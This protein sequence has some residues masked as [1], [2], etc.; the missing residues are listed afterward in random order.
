MAD[1][2]RLAEALALLAEAAAAAVAPE[3]PLLVSTARAQRQVVVSIAPPYDADGPA[4]SSLDHDVVL[5]LRLLSRRRAARSSG[6]RTAC[7]IRA[8]LSACR[9]HEC[10]TPRA[11]TFTPAF[12]A[13]VV[14]CIRRPHSYPEARRDDPHS[15]HP[16]APRLETA[17]PW[18]TSAAGGCDA[19]ECT[20]LVDRMHALSHADWLALAFEELARA[21][22]LGDRLA[23]AAASLEPIVAAQKFALDVWCVRDAVETAL[24]QARDTATDGREHRAAL[25]AARGAAERAA[26]ACLMRPWLA[27][28]SYG[29]LVAPFAEG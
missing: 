16:I 10:F 24:A 18:G 13:F 21:A 8:R 7:G 20:A 6:G 22:A 26:L 5:A 12:T 11:R 19:A 23:A 4:R 17:V 1:R 25:A 29:L 2:V 9:F 3:R 15:A 14:A 28:S 27:P